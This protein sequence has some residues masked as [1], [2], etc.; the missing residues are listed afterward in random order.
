MRF[1]VIALIDGERG[2]GCRESTKQSPRQL[3]VEIIVNRSINGVDRQV[4]AHLR[5]IA[6]RILV[7]AK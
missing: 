5:H 2:N 1:S 6:I 4:L 3:Q 7:H